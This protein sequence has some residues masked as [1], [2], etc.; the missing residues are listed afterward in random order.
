MERE[1]QIYQKLEIRYAEHVPRV[2]NH[3]RVSGYSFLV[4][5]RADTDLEK[6]VEQ[7][8]QLSPGDAKLVLFEILEGLEELH[9]MEIVHRDLKPSNILLIG[10]RWVLADFGISKDHRAAAGGRTF[11]LRGTTGYAAPEQILIGVEARPPADVFAGGKIA[12]YLLTGTTDID[13]VL[14]RAW[15]D[16]ARQCTADEPEKR[17][18]IPDVRAALQQI[19]E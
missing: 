7:K 8:G 18:C 1:A 19:V 3:G 5:E 12:V 9:G 14:S 10:Q 16:F 15:R 13:R 4:M 11:Q 2:L 17:P 6:H